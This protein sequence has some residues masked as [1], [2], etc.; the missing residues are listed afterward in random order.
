[1]RKPLIYE[2]RREAQFKDGDDLRDVYDPDKYQHTLGMYV[3][4]NDSQ[5]DPKQALVEKKH[6]IGDDPAD[7]DA[8]KAELCN[9]SDPDYD[10]T[11]CDD[12]SSDSDDDED[13]NGGVD[14]GSSLQEGVVAQ[15]FSKKQQVKAAVAK[16]QT[17]EITITTGGDSYTAPQIEIKNDENNEIVQA[18]VVDKQT[19]K[20]SH[21]EIKKESQQQV[22][23]PKP[24]E[25]K[26]TESAPQPK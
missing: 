18:K 24:Q 10:A 16:P 25:V 14:T 6:L 23:Q 11:L 4:T 12:S 26:K 13:D 21:S 19:D 7:D 22:E 15:K 3:Q 8:D 1:M 9:P 20:V 17:I 2:N 5:V